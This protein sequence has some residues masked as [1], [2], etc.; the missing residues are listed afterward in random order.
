MMSLR[1][2]L[3]ALIAFSSAHALRSEPVD[4]PPQSTA[5]LDL[6]GMPTPPDVAE[7]G[8]GG[9]NK[10]NSE[11]SSWSIDIEG[12]TTMI[13]R[14]DLKLGEGATIAAFRRVETPRQ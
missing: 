5:E 14:H 1:H 3:L 13:E 2:S 12:K 10:A 8:E 4:A 7:P 6:S 11:P 9:G